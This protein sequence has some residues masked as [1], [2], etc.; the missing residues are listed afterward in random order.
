MQPIRRSLLALVL[1]VG[2]VAGCGGSDDGDGITVFAAASLTE[3]FGAIGAAFTAEHPSTPVTFNFAAS[4]E[5]ATQVIEGAPADVLASADLANM[6]R[7]TDA[8]AAAGAPAVF[9]TNHST[10]VVGAGNPHGI[11]TIE[12]LADPALVIVICAPQVPCGSYAAEIFDRSGVSVTP[13]SYEQ[14]VKAVVTKVALGEADAGIAYETD[15]RVADEQVDSV[16]LPSDLD[17]TAQYPIAVTTASAAPEA[18]Q[19]FVDFVTSAEGQS[20]L[21]SFGFTA[22]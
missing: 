17:V 21:A 6:S 5:L 1:A 19:E 18:A 7:V 11:T 14:N 3:A 13:D 2:A 12:D 4:S 22:P 9:A 10:I 8:G 20:I 16:T 15:V